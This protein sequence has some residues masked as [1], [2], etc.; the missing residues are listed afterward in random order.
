[1]G[2]KLAS[3]G[4]A[5]VMGGCTSILPHP[6]TLNLTLRHPPCILTVTYP[7]SSHL[8]AAPESHFPPR[9]L[10]GN[11]GD[12]VDSDI[13]DLSQGKGWMVWKGKFSCLNAS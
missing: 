7:V 13:W 9:P 1:M 2:W 6:H 10:D 11:G 3:T 8:L 5:F 12:Q 4:V